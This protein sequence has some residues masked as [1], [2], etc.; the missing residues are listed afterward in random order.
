MTVYNF[1]QTDFY[2][3]EAGTPISAFTGD[4]T[5]ETV[6]IA[7]EAGAEPEPPEPPET[8]PA[9]FFGYPILTLLHTEDLLAVHLKKLLSEID[10]DERLKH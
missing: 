2:I 9:S 5:S 4:D 3:D 7:E 6:I 1:D 10:A 8:G